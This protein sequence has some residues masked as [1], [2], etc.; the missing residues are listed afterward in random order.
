MS[1]LSEIQQRAVLRELAAREQR[2]AQQGV[3]AVA[4]EAELEAANLLEGKLFPQQH[5]FF[6]DTSSRLRVACCTRRA[7]KST[8]DA[9]KI[10]VTLLRSPRAVCLYI[11]QT[12]STAREVL[13]PVLKELV[14]DFDL[15]F[16]FSETHLRLEHKR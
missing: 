3:A 5:A 13:W 11:A 12:S 14:A 2:V 4:T 8:G 15:P 6:F 16:N 7:G 9:I 10:L 1:K